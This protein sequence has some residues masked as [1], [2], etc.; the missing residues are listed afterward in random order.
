MLQD[1]N[2]FEPMLTIEPLK[3]KQRQSSPPNTT[4]N[5]IDTYNQHQLIEVKSLDVLKKYTSSYSTKESSSDS[6]MNNNEEEHQCCD[7]IQVQP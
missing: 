5:E 3:D 2:I 4:F 7:E 6:E 1:Y